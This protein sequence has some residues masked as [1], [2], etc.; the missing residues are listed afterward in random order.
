VKVNLS[1]FL[2]A[3]SVLALGVE[4][5]AQATGIARTIDGKAL[6]GT[7]VVAADGT[8]TITGNDD[9]ITLEVAE[10][11]SFEQSKAKPRNVQVESRVW[12]RSGSELPAKKL[13]G[14]AATSD[15]PATLIIRLPSG[16][17]IEV[18]LSTVRAIRQGGLMRP[19]P[20]L[21]KADLETPPENSDLLYVVK[22]GSSQRSSVSVINISEKLIDFELRDDLYEFD[23]SGVAAVVFGANT[24]FPPDRQ[25][26]P[27]ATISLVTGERLEG[28]LLSIGTSVQCRLDEG[29]VVEVPTRSLHRIDISSD[30]LVWMSEL[31][32]DVVQTPAFDRV[33]PWH[34]GRTIAGPGFDLSG[35][36]FERGIG[37]V[38]HTRL[39]YDLAGRFDL[40]EATIGIDDRGG[41]EAHAVFRVY[42]DGQSIFES[43][44]MTRGREPEVL[45]LELRKAKSLVLEVD[46]GK[47][48]D[49]GDFCAFA[50]ARVVQK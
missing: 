20:S 6:A 13:S 12:L 21:F 35:Q 7:L 17:E 39:T 11:V 10:L 32:P 40:F 28:K 25:S 27:R 16:I 3:A 44:P 42:V 50:D 5:S 46:F 22:N 18:P 4:A 36:H 45:R 33:W 24:G 41:P 47:N 23:F 48:Y 49:L 9:A 37:V 26:R 30:K 1:R 14:R 15:A 19:Q 29:C 8:M 31:T 34:I 2:L 38:P 43:K